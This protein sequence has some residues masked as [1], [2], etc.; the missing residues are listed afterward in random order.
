MLGAYHVSKFGLVGLTDT[1]RAELAP[2]WIP[3]ILV[4][5]GVIA[6]PICSRGA[7]HAE[8]FQEQMPA[9]ARELY[10]AQLEQARKNAARAAQRGLRP[11]AVG[12][13]IVRAFSLGRP[14]PGV[15]RRRMRSCAPSR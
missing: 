3:V 5:P 2:W 13:V 4:E 7:A 12:A 11:Q 8:R 9:R 14:K 1:L 15:F 6:T 10:A